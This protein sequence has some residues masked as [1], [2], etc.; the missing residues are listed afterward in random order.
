MPES[1]RYLV[2]VGKLDEARKAFATIAWWN[3]KELHWD[4][5]LYNKSGEALKR[6]PVFCS[7]DSEQNIQVLELVG[8]PL[9][10]T[11]TSLRTWLE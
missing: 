1:P 10:V 2:S 6:A 5:R 4:E 7:Q 11:E 3:R 8:L 9:K